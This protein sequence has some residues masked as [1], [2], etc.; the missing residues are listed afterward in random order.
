MIFKKTKL[1]ITDTSGY[2]ICRSFHIYNKRGYLNTNG[3]FFSSIRDTYISLQHHIGK[4]KRMLLIYTKKTKNRCDSS[5]VVY[6]KNGSLPLKKRLS[7][8]GSHIKGPINY[9]FKRRKLLQS[10]CTVI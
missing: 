2:L 8:L 5:N 9:N 10:F 4:K 1:Q 3:V 6:I 7:I